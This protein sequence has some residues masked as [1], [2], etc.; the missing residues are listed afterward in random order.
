MNLIN[1]QR[2][3]NLLLDVEN[4]LI[5]KID[6]DEKYEQYNSVEHYLMA[7]DPDVYAL[8][9]VMTDIFNKLKRTEEK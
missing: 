7:T 2:F 6:T 8:W 4:Y 5:Q 1:D 3:N 9:K